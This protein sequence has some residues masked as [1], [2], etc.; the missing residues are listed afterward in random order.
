MKK[1]RILMLSFVLIGTLCLN[2]TAAYKVLNSYGTIVAQGAYFKENF[3]VFCVL[4]VD[5]DSSLSYTSMISYDDLSGICSEVNASGL[6]CTLHKNLESGYWVIAV[7]DPVIISSVVGLIGNV[8]GYVYVAEIDTT[9]EDSVDLLSKILT[10]L[11]FISSFIQSIRTELLDQGHVLD[12]IYSTLD[13]HFATFYSMSTSLSSIKDRLYYSGQS[14]AYYLYKIE[15]HLSII[16]SNSGTSG[17]SSSGTDLSGIT[18]QLDTLTGLTGIIQLRADAILSSLGVA[19]NYLYAVSTKLDGVS[20]MI[21]NQESTFDYLADLSGDLGTVIS[22]QNSALINQQEVSTILS[23]IESALIYNETGIVRIIVALNDNFLNRTTNIISNQGT[24]LTYLS[25]IQAALI[26]NET[27]IG[28][29]IV[30]LNDNL[31]NRTTNIISNQSTILTYLSSIQAA[32]I[33]NETGIGRIIVGLNDNLLNRTTNI[34]SNQNTILSYLSSI[35]N[36][37]IYNETGIGRIIVALNENLL[38]RTSIIITNQNTVAAYLAYITDVTKVGTLAYN[39][40]QMVDLL[41]GLD[42]IVVSGDISLGDVTF[43]TST[44]EDKISTQ[45]GHVFSIQQIL[46]QT[47]QQIVDV[48]AN[49]STTSGNILNNQQKLIDLIEDLEHTSVENI[50]NI[51]I[52]INNSAYEIF[53]IIDADGNDQNLAD[54]SG[55][56]LT[57]T[58]RL[59]NFFFKVAFDDAMDSVDSALDDMTEF[60]LEDSLVVGGS[61]LWE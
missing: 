17:G 24:I 30:A 39:V 5:K 51:T 58:G 16:A 36:A 33:Y 37:L 12:D 41:A 14:A 18:T 50:Q 45:T 19:N 34:I 57:I 59:L 22:N 26:Y 6:N 44:L 38:G 54:F 46:S 27:G 40:D 4:D 3:G 55:D 35:Q 8:D 43:D 25:S 56:V 49:F 52:D 21:T 9:G 2:A 29:I 31:L 11:Y 48:S 42:N 23:N 53:Y 1:I 20:T 32:L 10:R 28:R 60:Y 61:S 47:Y 15:S 7:N 13:S